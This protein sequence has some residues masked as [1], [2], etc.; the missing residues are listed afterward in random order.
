MTEEKRFE[1]TRDRSQG[2][3]RQG[4]LEG[5]LNKTISANGKANKRDVWSI[6]PAKFK[7][8]HFA[9]F[10]E[11]LVENCIKAGTKEGDL[12]IDPFS[13]AGTT[14]VVA[15][16]LLRQYLGIELNENYCEMGRKRIAA[17]AAQNRMFV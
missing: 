7:D 3:Y 6:N 13:G 2:K 14:G 15:A 9:T 12:V 5:G 1:G 16:K 17:A 11:E 8:A 4:N 10:P